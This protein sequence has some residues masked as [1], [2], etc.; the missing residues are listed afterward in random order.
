MLVDKLRDVRPDGG[1]LAPIRG[2]RTYN[3]RLIY[4]GYTSTRL[5]ISFVEEFGIR[6]EA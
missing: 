3:N 1:A 6:D 2:V 4:N 5:P